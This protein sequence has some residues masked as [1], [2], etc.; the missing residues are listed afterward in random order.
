MLEQ[1][2]RSL[3]PP[4]AWYNGRVLTR[5]LLALGALTASAAIAACQPAPQVPATPTLA[6]PPPPPAS[7]EPSAP[8]ALVKRAASDPELVRRVCGEHLPCDIRLERSAGID[9]EGRRLFVVSVYR[10]R[11]VF[12]DNADEGGEP[13]TV[14]PTTPGA[15]IGIDEGER[16]DT[17]SPRLGPTSCHIFEYWLVVREGAVIPAAQLLAS[18]CNEGHGAAGVGEDTITIG[19]NSF[20]HTQA[21]GSNWR[22]SRHDVVELSPLRVVRTEETGGWTLGSNE[23]KASWNWD[24]FRGLTEWYSPPCDSDGN[25]P[26]SASGAAST[27]YAYSPI[28]QIQ[29]D[30]SFSASAW[31]TRGLGRCALNADATGKG[32]F[33]IQGSPGAESDAALRVVAAEENDIFVEIDDDHTIGPSAKWASDDRLELWLTKKH[34]GYMDH[35]LSP[36]GEAPRQWIIRAADGKVFAGVGKPHPSDITVERV[37]AGDLT[38]FH[39]RIPSKHEGITLAYADTDDGRTVER[40]I[41]T[42]RLIPGQRATLGERRSISA[43]TAVCRF[44]GAALAPEVRLPRPGKPVLY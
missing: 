32:G 17:I 11:D 39:I 22:W 10:G 2:Q 33:V 12:N 7:T 20:E 44:D 5:S 41:A 35:C 13:I 37:V 1:L 26:S 34:P 28:P 8:P 16:S 29:I 27:S 25:P 4:R 14:T 15:D 23:S 24:E 18:I 30:A 6:I 9:R 3:P 36:G 21:G 42:S 38:R 19:D 43:S 31:K 40:V